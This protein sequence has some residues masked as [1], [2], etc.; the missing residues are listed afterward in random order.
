MSG[1]SKWSTI[2]HQKAATDAKRS[3]SFTKLANAITVAARKG[4]D[5]TMNFTL[6]LAIDRA[7]SANMP[8]DNIERAVQRGAGSS[9][10]SVEEILYEAYGPSGTAILIEVA[11]DNKNRAIAEIK[12]VLNKL[13]GKLAESGSVSYLFEKKGQIVVE[14]DDSEAEMKIIDSGAD[15]YEQNDNNYF[16]YTD[17]K[18]LGAVKNNLESQELKVSDCQ[19]I[20]Q[21]KTTVD[22]DDEASAKVIRLMETLDNLDDV[23]EVS[24]NIS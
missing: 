17:Q 14:S 19:L 1:H 3:S 2:K 8:K 12:A 4:S 16:V 9:A 23:T 6:R 24:S 5:P 10:A 18:Q 20:W 22:L 15:D 7:K 11:T 13:G 21:P